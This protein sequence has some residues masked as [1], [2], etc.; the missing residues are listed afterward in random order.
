MTVLLA[1]SSQLIGDGSMKKVDVIFPELN[2][3]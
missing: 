1:V 3:L 2:E